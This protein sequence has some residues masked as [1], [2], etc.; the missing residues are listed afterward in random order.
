MEAKRSAMVTRR[1]VL[2]TGATAAGCAA[3]APVWADNYPSRY[4][5]L[6]LPFP[7]GGGTDAVSRILG[8]KMT[9]DLG[10]SVVID[11]RPGVAGNLATAIVAKSLNDGYTLLVGFN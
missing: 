5:H 8:E 10:Q 6:I 9:S 11:N 7:P 4:I 2:A 3:I 1:R